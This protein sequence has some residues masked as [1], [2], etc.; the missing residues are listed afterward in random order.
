MLLR[1]RIYLLDSIW[2][3]FEDEIDVL[4]I[5]FKLF[6]VRLGY[7]NLVPIINLYFSC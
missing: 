7:F 1:Y 6:D 3:F 2:D 5:V 4:K